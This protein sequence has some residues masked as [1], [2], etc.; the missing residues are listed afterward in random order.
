MRSPP[1]IPPAPLANAK[2]PPPPNILTQPANQLVLLGGTALFNVVANGSPPLFY[3]WW[4]NQTNLLASATNS[5]LTLSNV[6]AS[7]AG[8]YSVIVSNAFGAVGSSPASLSISNVPD[9]APVS[10]VA[11][12]SGVSGTPIQVACMVTNQGNGGASGYWADGIYFSRNAVFD[13]SAT[14]LAYVPQNHN[15]AAGSSY[16]WTNSATLPPVPSGLYYLFVVA[17]DPSYGYPVYEATKTNNTS[18]ALALNLVTPDLVPVSLQFPATITSTVPNPTIQ[19][20]LAVTNQGNGSAIGC[21][22]DRLYLSTNV[23]LTG[24]IASWAWYNCWN[25]ASNGSYRLTNNVALSFG[26]SGTYYLLFKT[27]DDNRLYESNENNNV[28]S[29][30]P[31]VFSLTQPDLLV[32]SM[33]VPTTAQIPGPLQV[34]YTITN[35]GIA[36]ASGPWQNQLLLA[37]NASGSSAQLLGSAVFNGSIPAGGSV[38]VTQAVAVAA[39]NLGAWFL[40]V[41]VDSANN[42]QESNEAN[43][44]AFAPTSTQVTAPDLAATQVAAPPSADIAQPVPVVFTITNQ[45]NAVAIGPWLNQVLLANNANGTGAQS[46]GTFNYTNLL[47]AG[48]STTV[49]QTVILPAGIIG[50]NYF[51]LFV[52]SGSN[53]AESNETNNTLFA[54]NAMV[55]KAPDLVLAQLS[56]P[57]SAQFGQTFTIQFAV[58]NADRK[59][60]V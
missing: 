50:T 25:L 57:G 36:V 18:V 22:N 60:V 17:D 13:T 51:G 38:T 8:L 6:D 33:S 42:V 39:N 11:P 30:V 40:G 37:T 41:F 3:Q 47:A 7:F 15:L 35:S 46:L 32:S 48:S 27:D 49:T 31:L 54:T 9:L 5:S 24:S 29:A 45:G 43:N 56:A 52:D 21:W 1:F 59:S 34:V 28:S 19:V 55:I 4:F 23:N 14:V 20:V 10:V 53:I 58:T 44:T 26:Q 16:S 2:V 12:A